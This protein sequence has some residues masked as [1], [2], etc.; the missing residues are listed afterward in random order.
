MIPIIQNDN[1]CRIICEKSGG[2]LKIS[3]TETGAKVTA[4]FIFQKLI[5]S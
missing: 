5:K 1:I 3:N 4:E 2:T